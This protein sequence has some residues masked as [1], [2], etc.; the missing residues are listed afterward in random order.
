MALSPTDPTSYTQRL[1][2]VR[3]AINQILDGSQS[4]SYEGRSM[5]MADISA[6]RKIEVD[7]EQKA[8]EETAACAGRNRI[9][10][11]TPIT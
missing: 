6:L 7:Y 3:A 11:F 9:S 2:K 8:A 1:K 5:T 10:Y 4:T